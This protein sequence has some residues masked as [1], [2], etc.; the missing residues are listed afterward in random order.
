[1]LLSFFLIASLGFAGSSSSGKYFA[2][3]L[4]IIDSADILSPKRGNSSI[5]HWCMCRKSGGR[6][7]IRPF[8]SF[9]LLKS[10][11]RPTT[12]HSGKAIRAPE[13][14]EFGRSRESFSSRLVL[15]RCCCLKLC[16]TV[17]ED[18]TLCRQLFIFE[19]TSTISY[20]A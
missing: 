9:C 6:V 17:Y 3:F 1:M 18:L 19:K 12:R 5:H 13:C 15:W 4:R 10:T 2:A 7:S 8:L 16:V 11:G 20:K 14:T